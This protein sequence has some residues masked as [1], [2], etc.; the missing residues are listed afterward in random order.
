[1]ST[2]EFHGSRAA[3]P[4]TVP[5]FWRLSLFDVADRVALG[6]FQHVSILDVTV[7]PQQIAPQRVIYAVK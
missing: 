7:I 1:L 6:G 2:P 4:K 3:G 5:V